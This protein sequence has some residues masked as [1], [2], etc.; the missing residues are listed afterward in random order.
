MNLDGG[1]ENSRVSG[2]AV[3]EVQNEGYEVDIES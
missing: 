3:F 1:S 2:F